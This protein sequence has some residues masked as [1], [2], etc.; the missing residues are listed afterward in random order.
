MKFI[1]QLNPRVNKWFARSVTSGKIV[2]TDRLMKEVAKASTVAPADVAAVLRA[3]A[4]AMCDH[5]CDGDKVKL[6]NIGTFYLMADASGNGVNTAEE[7][8]A[9]QINRVN[10][11]FTAEKVK[12][13]G[14]GGNKNLIPALA[15]GNITWERTEPV[16][17]KQNNNSGDPSTG[18]ETGEEPGEEP[19]GNTGGG[20]TPGGNGGGGNNGG[21]DPFAG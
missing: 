21:D 9:S 5:L 20:D 6:D 7:V 14:G 19:G 11:R 3:L 16:K 1:A 13:G 4:D 18:S 17:S 12:V 10:V 2:T 8:T 15:N